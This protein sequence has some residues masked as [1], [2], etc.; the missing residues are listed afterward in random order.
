MWLD[1]CDF[2]EKDTL[3]QI[4][5]VFSKEDDIISDLDEDQKISM[6]QLIRDY[7][8]KVPFV[9]RSVLEKFGSKTDMRSVFKK[10][11]E[12]SD[13]VP[14]CQ[15]QKP[16]DKA[17]LAAQALLEIRS[18]LMKHPKRKS[19][20]MPYDWS[21]R[22]AGELG[23]FD[24]FIK[25]HVP[26]IF[27]LDID[28]ESSLLSF[29]LSEFFMQEGYLKF[30]RLIDKFGK[31]PTREPVITK[32]DA[33]YISLACVS[34]EAIRNRIAG[35][36]SYVE[37]AKGI[38][39]NLI[40]QNMTG[41]EIRKARRALIDSGLLPIPLEWFDS[42]IKTTNSEDVFLRRS[43]ISV[44]DPL[45]SEMSQQIEQIVRR[46]NENHTS[47]FS[48]ADCLSMKVED[49]PNLLRKCPGIFYEP[50]MVYPC[51]YFE[52]V[53]DGYLS[54]A[55]IEEAH[56]AEELLTLSPFQHLLHSL[57]GVLENVSGHYLGSEY[58]LAWCAALDVKP[59][60]V[61]QCLQDRIFWSSQYS[62]LQIL[63]RT[64]EG[65]SRHSSSQNHSDLP[66]DV[67]AA[68][69][70]EI[71]NLGLNCSL[72][73]LAVVLKWG[74][75]SENREK[76]GLLKDVL[77]SFPDV[78]YDPS[79]MYLRSEL[80]GIVEWPKESVSDV[81]GIITKIDADFTGLAAVSNTILYYLTQPGISSYPYDQAVSMLGNYGIDESELYRLSNIFVPGNVVYLRKVSD[82][83]LVPKDS[84]SEAIVFALKSA[85]KRALDADKLIRALNESKRF[86]TEEV[87]SARN[88][89]SNFSGQIDS[90][91]DSGL[92]YFC[93]FSPTS[94]ILDQAAKQYLAL[95]QHVWNVPAVED[96]LIKSKENISTDS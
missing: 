20:L 14:E 45:T 17:V 77:R 71:E 54:P 67:A 34:A 62:D 18:I 30:Q 19:S 28:A 2:E 26:E 88:T 36:R 87:D 91:G 42:I 33:H 22:F 39:H 72:D 57:T 41:C 37:A 8:Q 76:Y 15:D 47:V 78:F 25:T 32:E 38:L 6:I 11:Q 92:S 52:H 95:K 46:G 21:H 44:K 3:R 74:K 53:V 40:R 65:K 86:S 1:N 85:S 79:N 69:K 16:S 75:H 24:S 80:E 63:I 9:V 7:G 55:S 58:I 89:L 29:S 51:A 96:F 94:L 83:V 35:G 64:K 82:S 70:R 23:S 90:P 13:Q 61:W 4:Q 5:F 31:P 93:Y 81:S 60:A 68:I 12:K 56:L 59:R 73:K 10:V 43:K 66:N 49:V 48:I 50:D 84:V 27:C